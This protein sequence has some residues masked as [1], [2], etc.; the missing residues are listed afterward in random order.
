MNAITVE[1]IVRAKLDVVWELFTNPDHIVNWYFASADWHCP[2]AVNNL[3]VHGDFCFRMEAKDKSFG[4]DFTGIYDLINDF[5]R[6]EYTIS[7]GRKVGISFSETGNQTIIT[8]TFEAESFHPAD[9]Q[10]QGWQAILSQ[11]KSYCETISV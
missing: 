5:N 1:V 4:F 3:K 2:N 11:F 9:I 7:D 10:K 8:E 6:I